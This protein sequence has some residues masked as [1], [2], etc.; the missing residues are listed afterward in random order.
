MMLEVNKIYNTDCL[1]QDGMRLINDQSIDLV[2][3]D[4]P[5]S[6]TG[7]RSSWDR[8]LP[9]DKIWRQYKRIIKSTGVIILTATNP[10][11][12]MLIMSNLEMYR[13]EWIWHKIDCTSNFNSVKHQPFRKH[14][15]CLVFSNGKITHTPNGGYI[16]YYPQMEAGKPYKAKRG[17]Q[18]S[19]VMSNAEDYK[20]SDGEYGAERYPGT[21]ITIPTERGLHPNQKPVGLFEYFIKT[22]TKEGDLILD[23]TA[24]SGTAMVAS[25]NTNRNF[26]GFE[27]KQKNPTE[28]YDVATK[29]TIDIIIEQG[30]QE[31]YKNMLI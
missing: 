30:K 18:K 21:V 22:Y 19:T 26:I 1:G 7:N 17:K 5:Y 8:L 10:F 3:A 28:F 15:L 20:L 14:E 13:Y 31:Q 9:L 2:L 27:W 16:T 12:S 24:G 23:N 29:R 25:V 4:L 6:I 11:A